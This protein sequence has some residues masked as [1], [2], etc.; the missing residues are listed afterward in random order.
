VKP[1]LDLP[2]VGRNLHDQPC[3]EVGYEGSDDLIEAMERHQA[4][5][6]WR[7]DEQVIGKFP[8]AECRQGFDL[9]IYPV[10]GRSEDTSP[11]L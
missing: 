1:T 2:G 3:V 7:P 10:G 11:D 5:T 8:S 6:G 9:H 4:E